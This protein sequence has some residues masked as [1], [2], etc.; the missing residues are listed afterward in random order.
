MGNRKP[1]DWTGERFDRLVAIRH[2]ETVGTHHYWIFR[3]D[4]G[5][6]VRRVPY[7][8]KRNKYNACPS[9]KRGPGSWAWSGVGEFPQSHY[10]TIYHSAQ[11]KGF[12]FSVSAAYL[13]QLFLEQDRKC[14]FTGWELKF[15]DSYED[16]ASRTASLDRIDSTK[17]YV[18]GNVQWV[19][20]DVN[21]LKKNLSDSKFIEICLAVSEH[22]R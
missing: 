14:V 11:A 7:N 10:R 22:I 15:I 18:E 2:D 12:E 9:C 8:V 6:E 3:C 16:K 13:W 19:H 4:C 20:R 5:E 1:K 17:G 21:K